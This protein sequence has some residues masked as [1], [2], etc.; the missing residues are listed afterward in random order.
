MGSLPFQA[1]RKPSHEDTEKSNGR[2]D[3]ESFR[4]SRGV[5]LQA[6]R[7]T[8]RS[9]ETFTRSLLQLH[10][11]VVEIP[12]D[13]ATHAHLDRRARPITDV[14]DEILDVGPRVRHVPGLHR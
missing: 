10:L 5:K 6:G 11:V 7:Q 12:L 2:P 9:G 13:E 8:V 14:L 4:G 1:P 3:L